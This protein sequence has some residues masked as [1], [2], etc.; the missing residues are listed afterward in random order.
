MI[1]T[2][3]LEPGDF[4][5]NLVIFTKSLESG[6]FVKNLVIFLTKFLESGDFVKNL[7][8]FTNYLESEDFVKNLAIFMKSQV[9]WFR[10]KI[11]NFTKSLEPGDF[12]IKSGY[13]Y[14]I[15]RI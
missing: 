7:V 6:D 14:E 1:F 15:S 8:I 9:W 2:E 13:F 4:V 10:G 11:G 12:V 5:K 3:S